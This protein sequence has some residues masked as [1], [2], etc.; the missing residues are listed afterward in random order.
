LLNLF[1]GESAINGRWKEFYYGL[2]TQTWL[3]RLI[4]M[5]EARMTELNGLENM[6][7]DI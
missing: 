5:I 6:G 1:P 7:D 3:E 4:I 2:V